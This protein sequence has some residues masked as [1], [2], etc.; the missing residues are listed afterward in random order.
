MT[1]RVRWRRKEGEERREGEGRGKSGREERG[2]RT[3]VQGSRESK[4]AEEERKD[5]RGCSAVKSYWLCAKGKD[6]LL[7]RCQRDLSKS[8]GPALLPTR[9]PRVSEC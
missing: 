2:E 5:L 6:S 3:P 8:T 4:K 7:S 1:L 9:T